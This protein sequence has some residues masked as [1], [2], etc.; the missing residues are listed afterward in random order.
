MYSA[1]KFEFANA[2]PKRADVTIDRSSQGKQEL[3]A[4]LAQGL[5]FPD[6]F[7]ENWD[8]LIDCLSDLSWVQAPEIVIDHAEV[9]QLSTRDLRLYLESLIDAAER[10][11]PGVLPRLRILFRNDDQKAIASA[12]SAP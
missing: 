6:H 9:P 2:A 5:S 11:T 4:R 1:D 7:G 8:A 3:L 12:L 10:R